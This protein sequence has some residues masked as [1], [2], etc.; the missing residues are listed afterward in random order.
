MSAEWKRLADFESVKQLHVS[1]DDSFIRNILQE[2]KLIG[3]ELC[4]NHMKFRLIHI[5]AAVTEE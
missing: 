1:V 4:K 5:K 2:F 3:A